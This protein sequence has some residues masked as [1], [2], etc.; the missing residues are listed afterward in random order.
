MKAL[1]ALAL[2]G[3]GSFQDPNTVIDLRML[4]AVSEPPE[5]VV[6]V[7]LTMPLDAQA[8]ALLQQLVP[9]TVC[10]LV[11]DPTV[12]EP[13]HYTLT[14]CPYS[15]D[16]RC[17]SDLPMHVVADGVLA[18]P[19][20]TTP[21]PTLCATVPPDGNLLGVLAGALDGDSLHGLAGVWVS[22]QFEV[23]PEGGDPADAIF[24]AKTMVFS[25]KIPADR[26][27]NTN[28]A[29]DR[30]DV[31]VGHEPTVDDPPAVALPLGRCVDQVAPLEVAAGVDLRLTPVEAAGARETYEVPTLDGKT[32]TFTEALTYEWQATAGH[33]T[34]GTTGGPKDLAGNPAP[35]F[36]DWVA[37]TR[38]PDGEVLTA[39][40]D[41]SLWVIQRDERFGV[42]WYESCVRVDP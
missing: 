12:D 7:D 25:P 40:V 6:D 16:E 33:W 42:H 36:T 41:V 39:P 4:G 30:V 14:M 13:L 27:P 23:G 24:G 8:G 18:D 10:G 19:D 1:L 3:C 21:E 32:E 20:T 2:I 17:N 15:A 35:L 5:Q 34:S 22:M 28:P 38:G 9:T 29:L 26:T 11:A 37:P 31:V